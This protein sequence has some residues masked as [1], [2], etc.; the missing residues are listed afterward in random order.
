MG[1][2]LPV[3]FAVVYAVVSVPFLLL[4]VARVGVAFTVR[5]LVAVTAVAG[6]SLVHPHALALQAGSA[7]YGTLVGHLAVGIGLVVLFRHGASLGGFGVVA[8]IAQER[9]GWRAGWV[10]LAFDAVVVLSALLV[11]PPATVLLSVVGAVLLN[12]VV[13]LNHRPGRYLA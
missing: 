8:L 6:S 4:A 1:R 9:L 5:S 13:A 2:A 3:P 10:Q 7:V 12:G 11:A